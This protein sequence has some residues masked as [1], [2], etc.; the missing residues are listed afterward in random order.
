MSVD[1][2][3]YCAARLGLTIIHPEAIVVG[4]NQPE[5]SASEMYENLEHLRLKP[6][7][8]YPPGV[9]RLAELPGP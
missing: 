8:E 3:M 4:V 7:G 6:V 1:M 9:G 2:R 5:M